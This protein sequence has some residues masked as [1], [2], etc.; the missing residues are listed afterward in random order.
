MARRRKRSG[1]KGRKPAPTSRA[2]ASTAEPVAAGSASAP[3]PRRLL[4][5]AL[6]VLAL[7]GVALTTYLTL[8]AWF[9]ARPAYCG[10]D[11][12]CDLVQSS[13]WSV[14]LGLP[15]SLWGLLTYAILARYLWRLRSR[16]SAWR[17]ALLIALVGAGVSW[18]LTLVSVYEIDATCPWC[19]ASF[20][21]MNA[22]LV[23]R[24][25]RRPAHLP[26]HAW[27]KALPVPV[28]IAAAVV[29]GLHLHFS[30]LFDPAAGPEDPYLK[31]LAMHLE[32]SGARFYGAWWC[33]HCQ[34]QKAHFT[35]SA[36]RLP[37]VECSP[38]GR[39]G[40]VALA[41]LDAGIRDY[42]TWIINGRRHT[43]VLEPRELARQSGYRG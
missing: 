17:T 42:P 15:M 7:A 11:S 9:G 26:E 4:D 37:Y 34:D 29:L 13:R 20:A 32:E 8:T 25:I 30:G 10:A 5:N 40:P 38:Q 43:G 35:A 16:A 27:G 31:G 21:I 14:F 39:D 1:G 36:D 22:I 41:C 18:F 6:L 3:A 23:L 33:P 28:G 19:L 24:L 2:A 12:G